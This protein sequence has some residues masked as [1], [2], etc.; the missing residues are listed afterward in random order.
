MVLDSVTILSAQKRIVLRATMVAMLNI[1]RQKDTGQ[2]EPV[3]EHHVPSFHVCQERLALIDE[4]V[5]CK[6]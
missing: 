4:S 3:L 1:V 6:R 2:Q 5:G